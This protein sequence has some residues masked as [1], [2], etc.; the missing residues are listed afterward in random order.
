MRQLAR[1]LVL[2]GV[3][4]AIAGAL[5]WNSLKPRRTAR[6]RRAT[7]QDRIAQ[8]GARVDARLRP[9]FEQRGLA[10][11]PAEITLVAFKDTRVLELYARGAPAHAWTH[12]KTY[13]VRGASGAL[14]PKLRE[15]D[16]QVPEGIYAVEFLHPNSRFHLSLKLDYP[17]AFD[18]RMGEADGRTDLGSDIM[19]HGGSSSIGCLAM[20]DAVVEELFVLAAHAGVTCV[21]VVICPTDFRERRA[22]PVATLPP[23][24]PALY[25]QLREALAQ[26]PRAA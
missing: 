5:V 19:I 15:G 22:V 23:W 20:G 18:R 8:F 7:V 6:S 13:A 17:N 11:P 10:Y 2:A 1:R 16:L 12:A 26:Y 4:V 24:T 9:V 25:A 21:R 3:L 14:G